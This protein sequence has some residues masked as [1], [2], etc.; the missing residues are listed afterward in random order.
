MALT[1]Q[2]LYDRLDKIRQEMANPVERAR[3]ADGREQTN[4]PMGELIKAEANLLE[5]IRTYGG[6]SDSK[7]TLA[8]HVR[9]DGPHGAHRG[10]R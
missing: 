8:Q 1:L 10:Y 9:G 5:Q 6:K 4:R 7:S 2:Q 3:F